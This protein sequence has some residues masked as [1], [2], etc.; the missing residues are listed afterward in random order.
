MK[1]TLT[2]EELVKKCEALI[3]ALCKN[4][5]AW[6]M[7]VPVDVNNDSDVILQELVNRFKNINENLDPLVNATLDFITKV[8][9][10]RA[11]SVETYAALKRGMETF[12]YDSEA[13]AFWDIVKAVIKES[14]R[15]KAKFGEQLDIPSTGPADAY[16]LIDEN[17][18]KSIVDKAMK[19]G[20]LSWSMVAAEELAE[21]I[22]CKDEETRRVELIQLMSVCQRWIATIDHLNSIRVKDGVKTDYT[23]LP[24]QNPF[25]PDNYA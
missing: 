20:V 4:P 10:G 17:A 25:D 24:K 5:S 15:A 2:N 9:D 23:G 7:R 16:T 18:M 1:T 8:E 21:V 19:E 11:K 12:Q 14:D 13:R 6:T 22:G 3:S